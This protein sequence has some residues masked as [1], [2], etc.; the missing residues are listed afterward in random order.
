MSDKPYWR[1]PPA[2]LVGVSQIRCNKTMAKD[3]H[4]T[5]ETLGLRAV[6]SWEDNERERFLKH[7]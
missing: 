2:N 1:Y 4:L 3:D 5:Q 7:F 6:S